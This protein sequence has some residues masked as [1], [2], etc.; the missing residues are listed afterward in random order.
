M[1]Y[2]KDL[3]EMAS[4]KAKELFYGIIKNI[5]LVNG[6]KEQR[7]VMENGYLRKEIHIKEIGKLIDRLAQEYSS[8]K[9]AYI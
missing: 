3:I 7:M 2:I 8:I 6:K 4:E 9:I 5:L 1:E